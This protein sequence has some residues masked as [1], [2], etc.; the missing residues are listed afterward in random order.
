MALSKIDTNEQ[1]HLCSDAAIV[2]KIIDEA[3]EDLEFTYTRMRF[4]FQ[5]QKKFESVITEIE[6]FRRIGHYWFRKPCDDIKTN[7][8]YL[9][10]IIIEN[11]EKSNEEDDKDI[12]EY[13][14]LHNIKEE[15]FDGVKIQLIEEYCWNVVFGYYDTYVKISELFFKIYIPYNIIQK[16]IIE[17]NPERINNREIDTTCIWKEFSDFSLPS[18]YNNS[19]ANVG[20][21]EE[22]TTKYFLDDLSDE[23]DSDEEN[24]EDEF[25]ID[26]S[27]FRGRRIHVLRHLMDINKFQN[28]KFS[29]KVDSLFTWNGMLED[30][31]NLTFISS[32]LKKHTF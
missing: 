19:T 27:E 17:C 22:Y 9:T 18:Y 20:L 1:A 26:D 23:E 13:S 8:Q 16:M 12:Y 24:S 2:E 5:H 25:Y 29:Y 6:L 7:N 4:Q 21:P 32:H 14:T 10:D 11:Y 28:Y 15:T 30:Y 31:I 3:N